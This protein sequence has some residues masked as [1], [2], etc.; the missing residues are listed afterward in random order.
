VAKKAQVRSYCRSKNHG[1]TRRDPKGAVCVQ[2]RG[3][4]TIRRD[5]LDPA[6]EILGIRETLWSEG[7]ERVG[8]AGSAGYEVPQ[9]N[10]HHRKKC[11]TCALR[12]KTGRV[13]QKDNKMVKEGSRK[14]ALSNP[15]IVLDGE[16][17]TR[18]KYI[19]GLCE[20]IL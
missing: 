12:W 15:M 5:R 17:T 11:V 7:I 6:G 4:S 10:E 1:V 20:G 14:S 13:F 9:P 3:S 19:Q 2:G 16:G 8:K 18:H